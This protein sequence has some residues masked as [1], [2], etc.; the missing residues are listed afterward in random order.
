MKLFL[1]EDAVS[2][3]QQLTLFPYDH[4]FSNFLTIPFLTKALILSCEGRAKT[5]ALEY[6]I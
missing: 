1:K 6:I 5:Y 4:L 2:L 3:K